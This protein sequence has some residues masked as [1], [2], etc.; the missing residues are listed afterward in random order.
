MEYKKIISYSIK[1]NSPNF[2]LLVYLFI[3]QLSD[4][5]TSYFNSFNIINLYENTTFIDFTDYTNSYIFV[6]KS[7][8]IY[9]GIS[10]QL[11]CTTN[12]KINKYT[13]GASYNQNYIILACL[14]DSLLSQ[15]NLNSGVSTSLLSYSDI[16]TNLKVPNYFCSLSIKDK[17]VYIG[18]S[19]TYDDEDPLTTNRILQNEVSNKYLKNHLLKIKT[20]QNDDYSAPIIDETFQIKVYHFN[21][22]LEMPTNS[23][24][25]P[26]QISCESITATTENDPRLLCGYLTYNNTNSDKPYTLKIVIINNDFNDIENEIIINNISNEEGFKLQKNND[27]YIRLLIPEY[28]YLISIK[29]SGNSH[30]IN[31]INFDSSLNPYLC[32]FSSNADLFYYNNE[33]IFSAPKNSENPISYYIQIKKNVGNNYIQFFKYNEGIIIKKI[34]GYW[35]SNNDKY[36]VIFQTESTVKYFTLNNLSF[37]FL[38]QT[39]SKT[40]EKVSDENYLNLNFRELIINEQN[41]EQIQTYFTVF[42]EKRGNP[43]YL[44]TQYYYL[45]N[46]MTVISIKTSLNNWFYFKFGFNEFYTIDNFKYLILFVPEYCEYYIKTCAYQC[47]KCSKNFLTCDECRNDYY[48]LEDNETVCYPTDQNI[49]YYYFSY[50]S[51][52]WKKCYKSCKFCNTFG[53]STY[54]NCLVCND[55]YYKS[56][57]FMGNCYKVDNEEK[58]ANLSKIITNIENEYYEIV[59]SC[60]DAQ[61]IYKIFETG[62][63]IYQCPTNSSFKIYTDDPNINLTSLPNI[64]F[65]IKYQFYDETVPIYL[66]GNVCYQKCPSNSETDKINNKCNCLYAWHQN[67]TS[68]EI[69]CYDFENKCLDNY[70]QYYINDTKECVHDGCP[71]N[72]YEYKYYCYKNKCPSNTK[73][74]SQNPF[75]CESVINYCYI[76]K[77]FSTVCEEN[78]IEGY[79]YKYGNTDYYLKN[80]NDSFLYFKT[81]TI[82]NNTNKNC[83]ILCESDI[84]IN[85]DDCIC[86]NFIYYLNKNKNIFICLN[87]TEA[88]ENRN[89]YSLNEKKECVSTLEDCILEG[90]KI[91]NNKCILNCPENTKL[92]NN[93]CNC[94]NYYFIDDNKNINCFS[95]DKTCETEGYLYSNSESKECFSSIN[96]CISK[97][98]FIFNNNCY[99]K[100]PSLTVINTIKPSY[101]SCEY[102]YNINDNNEYVCQHKYI[103]P[104]NYNKTQKT[105]FVIYKDK[106]YEKCPENTC[107][108]SKDEYF[109]N[110]I[111]IKENVKVINGI[112]IEDITDNINNII[113]N[114]REPI[115]EKSGVIISGYYSNKTVDELINQNEN[116]THVNLGECEYLLKEFYGLSNDTKLFILGVDSP[117]KLTNK[118]I[119]DYGYE[120]YLN[121]GTQLKNLSVCDNVTTSSLIKNEDIMNLETGEKYSEQGYDIYNISSI[122]YTDF[123]TSVSDDYNDITLQDRK[124]DIYPV[125][126]II[127]NEGCEYTSINYTTKRIICTCNVVSKNN[128]NKNESNTNDDEDIN[129][130]DYILSFFNYRIVVCVDYFGDIKNYY[131]NIGFCIGFIISILCF[132]GMFIFM[133][134][135]IDKI[136]KTIYANIPNKIKIQKLIKEQEKRRNK[137]FNTNIDTNKNKKRFNSNP[138]KSKKKRIPKS[139]IDN[140]NDQNLTSNPENATKCI[141]LKKIKGKI[142]IEKSPIFKKRNIKHFIRKNKKK[143]TNINKSQNDDS[144]NSFSGKNIIKKELEKKKTELIIDLSFSHLIINQNDENIDKNELNNVPYNQAIRIDKRNFISIFIS[145]FIN[146]INLLNIMCQNHQYAHFSLII[147]IYLFEDL[148]DLAMN[149]F[150][151]TDDVVSEKYHNKGKLNTFT[152]I[153]LSLMSNIFSSIIVYIIT[154][155]T[156]YYDLMDSII[157]DVKEKNAYL[158]NM[159]RL[160]KY[161]KIRLSMFYFL[162]NIINIIMTCYLFI[163]CSI[164]HKTQISFITNYLIG[165]LE[166]VGISVLMT[167]IITSLRVLS[168]EYKSNQLYNVSK[169]IMEHF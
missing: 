116:S 113:D 41:Y 158:W 46:E 4:I 107:L 137:L 45:N 12:A 51:K 60:Y 20:N 163:F 109:I 96:D 125:N 134:F 32:N 103:I 75:I 139:V 150:L 53:N 154:K 39:I 88:C 84:E 14:D 104:E 131:S 85:N 121:N 68:N 52:T 165:V 44:P 108:S 111:T 120:I 72:Y 25:F 133:K 90:Y 91:F 58:N 42:Y 77:N 67:K 99:L 18:F 81:K 31:Y 105:C 35:D 156:N 135:G 22:V 48:K 55:G 78:P 76:D 149:C 79:D 26:R 3:I 6:T 27:N 30:I 28:S 167:L 147:S 155:L 144:S 112:C 87:D 62:E 66:L 11:S 162:E 65:S 73:S 119:N 1:I 8:K 169:Y 86:E 164:Y 142:E 141:K 29:V 136:K 43:N 64:Y 101:C 128:N 166:S 69:I 123:C 115:V 40:I 146:E 21:Y 80:C 15:I 13:V 143:A 34:M 159:Y 7:Q 71:D 2:T 148:I 92:N 54:H 127:C 37:I 152:S 168:L 70:Y 57:E 56:Y 95:S 9:K 161:I 160:L 82:L 98:Y 106:C 63:C 24:I 145:I 100:C 93:Y 74:S 102:D 157:N 122:F 97:N 126:A 110:C 83:I 153:S 36:L 61:K 118:S 130:S 38:L 129:Y 17:Y 23:E 140:K 50:F 10:P 151:Y 114:S 94:S 5:L 138:P 19:Y 49:P 59:N 132:I 33:H 117:T 16:N 124:Q 47:G 89:I